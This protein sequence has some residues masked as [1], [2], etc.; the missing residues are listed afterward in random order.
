MHAHRAMMRFDVGARV[1]FASRRDG[2]LTGTLVKFNR[3]TVTVITEDNRQWRVPPEILSPIQ[4]VETE[5]TVV[6]HD[7]NRCK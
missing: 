6:R 2:R 7:D 3:K 5:T 1:S 4:N